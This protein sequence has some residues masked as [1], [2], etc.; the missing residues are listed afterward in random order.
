MQFLR[1][2]KFEIKNILKSKF[3]L[4]IGIL[5]LAISIIT[6]TISFFT[7]KFRSNMG[8]PMPMAVREI[9]IMGKGMG[10]DMPYYPGESDEEPIIIDGVEIK[11]NSPLYWQ[12][13]SIMDEMGYMEADRGSFSSD[14][15]FDLVVLSME[16][17]QKYY[18][19]FAKYITE[20]MDYRIDLIWQGV[21]SV[22]DKFIYEH[23]DI[24]KDKL[25]EAMTRRRW[26]EPEPFEE[27][28][29]KITSGEKLKG[30]EEAEE[31]IMTLNNVIETNDFS[32]YID[33]RI[34]QERDNIE[35]L[36]EQIA[37]QE[38]II[39]DNPS[40]EEGINDYIE[41]MKKQ[42]NFIETSTIPTLE[43]RLEKNIIP[44]EDIWQNAA[45]NDIE[46]RR[47]DLMYR[48][49]MSEEDFVKERYLIEQY[50]TYRA[51]RDAMQ[52]EIDELNNQIIIAQKSLDANKPDMKFVPTAARQKTASNLSYSILVALFSVLLGGWLMASEFQQGT[53]RLL[54]IRPKTRTKILMSK[55]IAA[56][57]ISL[58]IYVGGSLLNLVANGAFFGFADFSYPNFTI[59]GEIGFF[60]YYLPKFI[61]CI[62]PI[63]F[64]FALSFLLSVLIKNAAV[65]IV[66]PIA[67]F[68]G[69]NIVLPLFA[70]RGGVGKWL[71]YTP[72]PYMD[73][74]SFFG[75][76]SVVKYAVQNGIPIS[77][78]YG[79]ILLSVLA[80]VS[81]LLSIFTF[82]RRDITN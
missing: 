62:M 32:K 11:G 15:V 16:E 13:K 3:I 57:L 49:I 78:G 64:G 71:A 52:A 72:I 35:D 9:A 33:L 4:I 63:I 14:E 46:W 22:Y 27:K 55:F 43:Y 45:L 81:I 28:Y 26:Y 67:L 54:M 44:G 34:I 68:L 23:N 76:Y 60:A 61:A 48:D 24:D 77:L 53:I 40:Q 58:I 6:P 17:E 29:I 8:Y 18:V 56:F 37:A 39:V 80:I 19:N 31:K 79:I 30:I 1:Q 69:S 65:A 38:E 7:E 47:N 21:D 10:Y 51:Y 36:K 25:Y 41:S 82:R 74:S 42:I 12:V 70:Y 2:I 50:K 66:I 75:D 73:I 20:P 5:V 59:S